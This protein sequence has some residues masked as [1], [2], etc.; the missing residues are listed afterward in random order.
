MGVNGTWRR[1]AAVA[2]S[3]AL[4]A[5]SRMTEHGA[6][7]TTANGIEIAYETIGDPTDPA[8]LLVM[9]LGAQMIT[10]DDEFCQ[11]LVDRG[12]FVIRYDNRDVG[13]STKVPVDGDIDI[14]AVV[15]AALGGDTSHAPYLLADM[16]ADGL[17]L[18]DALG[19][20]RAHVV[21]AS[22]G[23]MI[24]QTIAIA[25]P[26]RVGVAHLDHVDDRRPGRRPAVARGA[27]GAAR[28]GA[29][30][31]RGL[32]RPDASRAAG[33]SA[34]PSTST[35]S[36]PP[37]WPRAASTA[38]STRRASPTSSWPSSS[39][40]EPIRRSAPRSTCPPSSSTG[41]TIRSWPRRAASA[42][43]R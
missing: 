16:A 25:A 43:P 21:G 39:L 8:L 34:A 41:R 2:H 24:A 32:H 13:L 22:M 4:T 26:D 38:A 30:R 5:R 9:G 28:A 31:A 1:Q 23:G 20:E 11:G 29:D 15:M 35:P 12:F 27:A 36:G 37:R 33:P 6:M 7:H 40:A 14:A 19:I 10:W 17:G 42:R 3:E 18:L